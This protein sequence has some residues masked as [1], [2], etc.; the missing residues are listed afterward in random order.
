MSSSSQEKLKAWLE[1]KREAAN[2]SVEEWDELLKIEDDDVPNA[3]EDQ[4]DEEDHFI[5]EGNIPNLSNCE[6]E[7]LIVMIKAL[8]IKVAC[9]NDDLDDKDDIIEELKLEKK[10]AQPLCVSRVKRLT[11]L[12]KTKLRPYTMKLNS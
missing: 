11:S 10:K 12:T 8:Q 7:D 6:K 2:M 5:H 1:T 9:L 3:E 4:P